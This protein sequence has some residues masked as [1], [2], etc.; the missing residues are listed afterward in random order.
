M[1]EAE[2]RA[3]H[4]DPALRAA[5]WGVVEGSRVRRE[6]QI[7]LGRLED[8]D[9]LPGL[10]EVGRRRVAGQVGAQVDRHRPVHRQQPRQVAGPFGSG[11]RPRLFSSRNPAAIVLRA[12]P[13]AA[14]TCD[15]PPQPIA[16]A[17]VAAQRRRDRSFITRDNLLYFSRISVMPATDPNYVT[18]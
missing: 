6:Y 18:C 9:E 3:E 17:S 13:I 15:T 1:N 8:G 7:T 4:I 16:R 10:P 14:A 12:I 2:T 5:G 11:R